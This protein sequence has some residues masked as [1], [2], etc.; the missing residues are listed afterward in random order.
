MRVV[1]L[2]AA[3]DIRLEECPIPIPGP[4]EV[5]LRMRASGICSGDIMAWYVARKAPFVLGHELSGEIVAVGEGGARDRENR[6]FVVGDRVAVHHHAPC[7]V[8]AQCLR[9]EFVACST[10]RSSH[11]D[12]G[13]MAE[14]VRVPRENLCDTLRLPD[15]VSF[16][17]G[18][19]VEPL[20]CVMKSLRRGGV[21]AGDLLYIVGLG[22]MGQLH[23]LAGRDIGANV[24]ASD[25]LESRRALAE[26]N[27]A[28]ALHPDRV[29]AWMNEHAARCGADRTICGPGTAIALSSALAMTANGGTVVMFTPLAPDETLCLDHAELYFRD[30]RLIAS[31]SC[32]PDDTAAALRLIA[33]GVVRAE[34]LKVTRYALEETARA[35][36]DLHAARVIKPIVVSD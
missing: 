20:A 34:K 15:E 11:L 25:F 21:G 2:Y 17:D 22:V 28:V 8:C 1:V 23:V 7:F 27:G 18:S 36:A 29:G 26:S 4:G 32:G 6:A 9:G 5:L 3:D 16:E 31:Y 35:Y 30:L 14:Y 19:L 24:V 12:P 33:R 10:W 13:G